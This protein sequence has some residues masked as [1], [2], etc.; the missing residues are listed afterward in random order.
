MRP[1][2]VED[3][4]VTGDITTTQ[5]FAVPPSL[6][7]IGIDVQRGARQRSVITDVD[8]LFNTSQGLNGLLQ[9]GRI[10]VERF[11]FPRPM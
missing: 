2:N 7:A 3:A 5:T 4:P 1:A 10:V 11:G 8:V 6:Q 9:T